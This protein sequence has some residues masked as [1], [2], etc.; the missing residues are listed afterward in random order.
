MWCDSI[1]ISQQSW[2]KMLEKDINVS[3]Y[4]LEKQQM[5]M[6]LQGV[7]GQKGC[8]QFGQNGGVVI[9]VSN[10]M[11]D[12]KSYNVGKIMDQ[13][14]FMLDID[15]GLLFY[16]CNNEVV[17]VVENGRVFSGQQMNFI[18]IIFLVFNDSVFN[19]ILD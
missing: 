5:V 1:V 16:I 10:L 6:L 18:V 3:V 4:C 19:Y 12:G 9:K 17:V 2:N 14:N 15:N 7:F 11:L 8:F 13:V